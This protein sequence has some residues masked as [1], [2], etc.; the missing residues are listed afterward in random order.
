MGAPTRQDILPAYAAHSNTGDLARALGAAAVGLGTPVAGPDVHR[1]RRLSPQ[2][3]LLPAPGSTGVIRI[4][5]PEGLIRYDGSGFRVLGKESGLPATAVGSAL[6]AR[7]AVYGSLQT[8]R[9]IL[10]DYVV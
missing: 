8:G 2:R 9:P 6:P 4:R 3:F 1:R 10:R 7:S 5:S